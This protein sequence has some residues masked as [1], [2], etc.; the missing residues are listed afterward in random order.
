[1]QLDTAIGM[2][3]LLFA[4]PEQ[5]WPLIDDW[6]EFLTQHHNNRA[7]SKDTWQQLYDFIKVRPRPERLVCTRPCLG[8]A[9]EGTVL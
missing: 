2:W 6:C 4:V 8:R 3:Q 9:E 5:R 1:M 7:I